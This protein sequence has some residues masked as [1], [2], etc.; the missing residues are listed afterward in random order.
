MYVPDPADVY[1]GLCG[2]REGLPDVLGQP[3]QRQRGLVRADVQVL[4]YPLRR[5]LHLREEH[6]QITRVANDHEHDQI[7]G[8]DCRRQSIPISFWL[9]RPQQ[10]DRDIV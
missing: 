3:V 9:N 8:L 4:A 2:G 1:P 7:F 5:L 10:H 6:V